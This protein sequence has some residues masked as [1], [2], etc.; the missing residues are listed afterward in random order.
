MARSLG[1]EGLEMYE[2]FLTSLDNAYIES[3]GDAI[4]GAGFEMP[5]LCCS[6]NF[7]DPDPDARKRAVE[8]ES[9]MV[10]VTR[11]LGGPGA[12]CRVLSGQA[13]PEIALEQGIEER[14]AKA[15]LIAKAFRSAIEGNAENSAFT[16]VVRIG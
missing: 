1:A 7:T 5:M 11:R 15:A 6:P 3:V 14:A 12:A 4:H 2:G 8:H 10:R 13:Y 9:E 16:V